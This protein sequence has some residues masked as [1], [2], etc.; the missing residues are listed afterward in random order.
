VLAANRNAH[1][2]PRGGL[3]T[4][5]GSHSRPPATVNSALAA[6]DDLYL[7]QGNAARVELP[8]IAPRALAKRDAIRFLRAVERNP[9]AARPRARADPFY[10]GT[11]IS[12]TVA[13]DLDDVASAPAK[14]SSASAPKARRSAR[15]PCT[16]SS[17]MRSPTGLEERQD[18]SGATTA[19]LYLSQR[20][21]R[22]SVLGHAR[23]E[24][25]RA[26]SRPTHE[27]RAEALNLLDVDQ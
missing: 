6:T 13:L 7:R 4:S 17:A 8:T 12:E 10:A 9:L 27:D 22:R 14:A 3:R 19:A 1:D 15:S 24:S 11:R 26:D 21:G 20:G 18:W 2:M 23:L 25:T 16:P 5:L